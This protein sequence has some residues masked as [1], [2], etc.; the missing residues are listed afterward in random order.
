MNIQNWLFCF[1]HF[2]LFAGLGAQNIIIQVEGENRVPL[3]GA[4]ATLIFLQ[5]S[6][7]RHT[8][9]GF[10]GKAIFH[11]KSLGQYSVEITYIGYS[12]L[13]TEISVEK[14]NSQFNIQLQENPLTLDEVTIV[15][16]RPMLRQDGDKIIVDPTPMLDISTNVLE[17]MEATPGLFVDQDGGIYLGNTSPATIYI[18][19]REQRLGTQDITNLLRSLPPGSIQRIEL[20][21]NPSARYDAASS[22]GIINIVLKKGV[23]IGRFGSVQAGMNQGKEGNLF[24]GFSLYSTGD[25]SGWYLNTNVNRDAV[26]NDLVS[27]RSSAAPFLL[28][29]ESINT[30]KS[31]N[32]FIGG[33]YHLEIN[34]KISFSYDGRISGNVTQSHTISENSMVSFE[35]MP[36][37]ATTNLVD[38]ESPFLSQQH[39]LNTLFRWDTLGSSLDVRFSFAHSTAKTSQEYRNEFLFP[40]MS[41]DAG[42]GEWVNNRV[43]VQIQSDLTTFLPG[44]VNLE[45]GFKGSYMDFGNVSEFFRG[46]NGN[47]VPDSIRNN[48]YYYRETIGAA[49]VQASKTLFSDIVLKAGIRG[50]YTRMLGDQ[51]IPTEA[52]FSV[53]RVDWFP[54]AFLSRRLVNIAGYELKAFAIYRKTLS[55]PSYQNLNPGIRILDQF[56]YESGNPALAPQFTHNTELNIS[57]NDYPI[58]AVGRNQT[59]GIISNVLYNDPDNPALTY[60]TFDNVGSSVETYFRIVMGL[61]PVNRYFGV[62][63]AQYNHLEYDGIYSDAPIVFS[64]GSWRL[65]TFHSFNL[66]KNTRIMASGFMLLN[67]QMNLIELGNIGQLNLTLSQ[68]LMNKKLQISLFIRDVLRTMETPFILRQSDIVFEGER[69]ADNQRVGMTLRYQFG[70]RKKD[71][72]KKANPFQFDE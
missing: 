61:P 21:R 4:N 58:F 55:R 67:G 41:A 14:G 59:S 29:Q 70:I 48:E 17:I 69:Y 25:R 43:F 23:K 49:Y 60:N 11:S 15:S 44:K 34:D 57:M 26:Q 8:T 46:F 10:D 2:M 68:T 24:A 30:R 45:A 5:D 32:G 40:A 20:I 53:N 54:Y 31:S 51:Q 27:S 65:F 50:E 66:T 37:S 28:S 33:G 72:Q 22:G 12:S 36:L 6:T 47:P 19:G 13:K 18:N 35:N 71:D 16:R 1:F 52:K 62:F 7:I 64:R 56:N 38:N 63:G 42:E 39:D 3:I 9:T